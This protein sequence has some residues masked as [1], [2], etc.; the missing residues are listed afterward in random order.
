LTFYAIMFQDNDAS[1]KANPYEGPTI[2]IT[3]E[4]AQHYSPPPPTK[5][6]NKEGL[7]IGLPVS[8]GFVFLVV[9]GLWFGMRKHRNIGLGNIMGRRNKG[10]GAGKSRRQRLG[11]GK[12]GAIRLEEREIEAARARGL[13]THT[14]GD[15]LGSL[16]SDDEIRPAPGGNQ[17]RDEIQRQQTGR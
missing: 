7:M 1:E 10:Y 16:V 15:S 9:I 8:L 11:L 5:A 12:K 3:N 2:M 13:P 4:P 6:P 14:R 17:F